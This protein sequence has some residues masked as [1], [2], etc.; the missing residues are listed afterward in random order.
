MIKTRAYNAWQQMR[1]RCRPSFKGHQWYFDRGI[2]V[3]EEWSGPGGFSPFYTHMGDCPPGLTL[4]R[5]DNNRGYEPGNCR[6][7]SMSEQNNNSR[8]V[9][10]ITLPDDRRLP[11]NAACLSIGISRS[12]LR[13][14]VKRHGGSKQQAFD[15]YIN[16]D[17]R[18]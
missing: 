2:K 11:L 12:T 13:D 5:I 7:A 4:D 16:R 3:C 1:D 6:W 18:T 9:H 15:H 8:Q 14:R 17:Q 10:W